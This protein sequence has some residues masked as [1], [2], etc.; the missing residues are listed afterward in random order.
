[1]KGLYRGWRGIPLRSPSEKFKSTGYRANVIVLAAITIKCLRCA[2]S[3]SQRTQVVSLS[4]LQSSGSQS[5]ALCTSLCQCLSHRRPIMLEHASLR[6]DPQ[7]FRKCISVKSSSKICERTVNLERTKVNSRAARSSNV[8][9]FYWTPSY[10]S[11]SPWTAQ[12]FQSR[13]IQVI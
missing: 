5:L 6:F 13:V 1:M 12:H 4:S 3:R 10:K 11:V 9:A 2:S 7:P 8:T